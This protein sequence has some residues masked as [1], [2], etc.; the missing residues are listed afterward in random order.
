MTRITE[1]FEKIKNYFNSFLLQFKFKNVFTDINMQNYKNK[2][3][4]VYEINNI[5]GETYILGKQNDYIYN[6]SIQKIFE[7][8]YIFGDLKN[9]V[10]LYN[11]LN[12]ELI[13]NEI[14]GSNIINMGC[15]GGFI[16]SNN[17]M[18]GSKVYY[19]TYN[20]GFP[21]LKRKDFLFNIG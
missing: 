18:K 6:N 17:Y 20:L 2:N 15:H 10:K 7:I 21:K 1:K 5:N 13:K 12:S 9:P 16:E 4:F 3:Y 19:Y 8:D 11:S 14:K